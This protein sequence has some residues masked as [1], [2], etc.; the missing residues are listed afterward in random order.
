MGWIIHRHGALYAEEYGL[1]ESFES[2]VARIGARETPLI[3]TL[4][5][6]PRYQ[7]SHLDL[8]SGQYS[9]ATAIPR[10]WRRLWQRRPVQ[11]MLSRNHWIDPIPG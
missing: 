11:H 2:M 3:A 7:G 9:N 8:R 4:Q 10:L 6:I 1:D 5:A